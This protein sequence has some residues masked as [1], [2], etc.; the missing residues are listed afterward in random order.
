MEQ[1]E[2][3]ANTRHRPRMDSTYLSA[4]AN[5]AHPNPNHNMEFIQVEVLAKTKKY[6]PRLI[7]ESIENHKPALLGQD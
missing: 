6:F 5:H 2:Q 3:Q 1:F 7:K 4:I